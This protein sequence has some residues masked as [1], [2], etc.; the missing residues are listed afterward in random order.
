MHLQY[1]FGSVDFRRIF[2][3]RLASVAILVV[4]LSVG[5]P[6]TLAQ[7]TA[8]TPGEEIVANLAAG[9]VIVAVVKD[10]IIVGTIEN[11]IEA[12]THPPIPV[13]LAGRRIGVMLGAVDWFSVT[14]QQDLAR[15][16]VELPHLHSRVIPQDPRLVQ[17]QEGVEATD[18]QAIGQGVSERLNQVVKSL[19]SKI[20]LPD[21]EPIAELIIADYIEGYGPEVWQALFSLQQDPEHGDY[22]D[23]RVLHPRYFQFYPP[24]KGEP[25]TL[26]EFHY[27]PGDKSP[28]LLDLLRQNDPRLLKMR[29]SLDANV[30]HVAEYILRGELQKMSAADA[31]QFLRGALNAIS[32]PN[33]RQTMA[34]VG[35]Q[36]GFQWILPPPPEHKRPGQKKPERPEGAPTLA[37]PPSEP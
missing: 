36:T 30:S 19:H 11:P 27:P 25:R 20:N 5:A 12:G 28:T 10:A 37:K 35:T 29:E 2:F 13:P 15:L 23:S 18:I 14:S 24:E 9:R 21:D 16:D 32:P 26:V 1:L 17:P 22:W 6:R 3:R 33:S 34:A 4:A 8:E 7:D 31:I